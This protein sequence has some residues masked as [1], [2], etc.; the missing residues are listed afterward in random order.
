MIS[1]LSEK[2]CILV[3]DNE[4]I[5]INLLATLLHTDYQIKVAI[6]GNGAL[7]TARESSQPDLILLDVQMP[8]MNGFDVCRQLKA[9]P[10]TR[11]IPV[12][13][14]TTSDSKFE[15]KGLEVGAV[16][17]IRKPFNAEV[18][19]LR[20]KAHIEIAR[21]RKRLRENLNFISNLHEYA[22]L[23]ISV[24][25]K[26]Y[27]WLLLNT[28]SLSY[29]ECTD[30]SQAQQLVE[31]FNYIVANDRII[32]SHALEAAFAGD[33][34][35]LELQL[36][37]LVGG[38]RF[39][40]LTLSP[41][42]DEAQLVTA[43]MLM[44]V[45]ITQSKRAQTRLQ[46][47]A[48]VFENALE[49]ILIIDIDRKIIDVNPAYCEISGHTKQH[50]LHKPFE[51]D[52]FSFPIDE[53]KQLFWQK[54]DRDGQ[55]KG[56][57][58]IRRDSGELLSACLSITTM[59][60]LKQLPENYLAI[61]SDISVKKKHAQ[62]LE[63][64]ANYDV[65]TGLPNRMLL[66]KL[67]RQAI[68]ESM[69]ENVCMAICFLDL[70]GFKP[71]NDNH[72][73]ET[74]DE[75]LVATANCIR[76]ALRGIDSVARVGGDEFVVILRAIN[77]A[78]DCTLTLQRLLSSIK[79]GFQVGKH[80][81][82]ITASIGVAIYPQDGQD[83]DMLLRHAD[84]AMYIAKTSGKNRYHFFDPDEHERIQV[85][86]NEQQQIRLALEN[87]EFEL[88]FQPKIN[89][90][91]NLIIG[92]EALIRWRHPEK[93]L[94]LPNEFLP[95]IHGTDIEIKIGKWVIASALQQQHEWLL[96][97]L[98][99]ELSINISANHL[100][101]AEFVHNLQLEFAKFPDL[102]PFSIQ[103]EVLETAALEDFDKA[104][105]IIRN[106]QAMGCGFALDDFGTGYSSLT[107]LCK[108][109]INT[110]KID[111]VFVRD[112]LNDTASWAVVSG[113]VALAKT[114]NRQIVA[115]GVETPE[116]YHC[117]AEM[118]VHIAQG[119]GIAKPMCADDF[120]TWCHAYRT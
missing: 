116:H 76:H 67:I 82:R 109:P 104:I 64:F 101:S 78:R 13:F 20:V 118:G 46:L 3:V 9:D 43:V 8:G 19:R 26:D 68:T 103:I 16:D 18:T 80:I 114:L 2:P 56:E 53:N 117:L 95:K 49:G 105:R 37:G 85:L 75:V 73:H 31:G 1:I 10:Y 87:R 65:L 81:F 89:L 70:D 52:N 113:V 108:L 45:D 34:K 30:I 42:L 29:L 110:I 115:E 15:T 36:Q 120:L 62:E 54:V 97:G 90:L 92:A 32:Y 91:D 24:L 4:P 61:V 86:G 63:K 107:Y 58:A 6:D 25:S 72:G 100:Q 21:S 27:Q 7:K 74:G 111:Q 98:N 83:S 50:M 48:K 44:G 23:A 11:D 12:I 47:M 41:I 38:K 106:C 28:L 112:M 59:H 77:N 51:M 79:Q 55:W 94:L 57:I 93:G 99:L 14:I 33:I 69:R 96:A 119:F 60:N 88:Y 84:H 39:V 17:Y 5:H 102:L 71:I 35:T 66:A 40:Q 22:P